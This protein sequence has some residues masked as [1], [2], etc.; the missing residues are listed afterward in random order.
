METIK[1]WQEKQRAQSLF[2]LREGESALLKFV[3]VGK[4]N[5]N[6]SAEQ[7]KRLTILRSVGSYMGWL[8]W[9]N[10]FCDFIE[11]YQT[12]C[13]A[14]HSAREMLLS[15]IQFTEWEEHNRSK[16]NLNISSGGEGK[17]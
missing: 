2:N 6:N 1:G 13:G 16:S 9:V 3:Q 7:A 12:T 14:P 4:A 17:K 5:R 11:D 10:P 8:S 15:A